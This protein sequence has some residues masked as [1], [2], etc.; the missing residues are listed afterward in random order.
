MS[1]WL[2]M[3]V[4]LLCAE[5]SDLREL[6]KLAGRDDLKS[7]Y[8]GVDVDKLEI[9]DQDL[10]GLEFS[11]FTRYR[12]EQ[13]KAASQVEER[14]VFLL[15]TVLYDRVIGLEIL[16]EYGTD[17][18]RIMGLAIDLLRNLLES[19]PQLALPTRMLNEYMERKQ[20]NGK[21]LSG[22]VLVDSIR[23]LFSKSLPTS[24]DKLFYHMSK[25]LSKYSDVKEYLID[26]YRKSSPYAF[27]N[28]NYNSFPRHR[29][30]DYREEIE[31]HL[32]R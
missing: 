27:Q 14:V 13:I 22:V 23:Q 21:E 8:I 20:Q 16:K 1:H 12:V 2:D 24:R 19:Q 3:V 28:L 18:I 7:F 10:K 6:A 17:N 32:F 31:R 29:M 9:V 30:Y 5:T 4:T 26:K 25:K 11:N 15:D